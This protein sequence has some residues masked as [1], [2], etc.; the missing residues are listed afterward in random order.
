MISG[1]Q[2]TIT[3]KSGEKV[4]K[5]NNKEDKKL[6]SKEKWK[7]RIKRIK[8]RTKCLKH[9]LSLP[10]T[11]SGGFLLHKVWKN[12]N[13]NLSWKIFV[14]ISN[15][16]SKKFKTYI[17]HLWCIEKQFIL[18]NSWMCWFSLVVQTLHFNE[19]PLPLKLSCL[20]YKSHDHHNWVSVPLNTMQNTHNER[21][22][23]V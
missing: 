12:N 14:R 17:G 6:N 3:W 4:R 19:T 11:L 21:W 20:D 16:Y 23:S 10:S 22:A 18:F 15:R 5:W 1:P 2:P 8:L 13:L 7:T 9:I